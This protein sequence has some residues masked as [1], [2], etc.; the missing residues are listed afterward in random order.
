M[1]VTYAQDIQPKIRPKDIRCMTARGYLIGDSQWMCDPAPGN[2]FGDHGNA[3]LVHSVL[4]EGRMPPDAPWPPDWIAA[5][6]SW[7][8][9]SFLP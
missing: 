4:S 2:G 9:G 1:P 8:D 6:Q 7:I 5:Y 3:R